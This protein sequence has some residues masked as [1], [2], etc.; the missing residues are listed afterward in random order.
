MHTAG[1]T[2]GEAIDYYECRH[3]GLTVTA[4]VDGCPLCGR[5]IAHYSL[6]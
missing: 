3:C 2:R 5:S 6:Q 1:E 4:R